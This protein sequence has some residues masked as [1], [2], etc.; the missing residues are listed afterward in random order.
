MTA[1]DIV[2]ELR[3]E[4]RNLVRCDLVTW[5]AG[6]VSARVPGWDRFLTTASEVSYDGRIPGSMVLCTLDGERLETDLVGRWTVS[7]LGAHR[8]PAVLMHGHGVYGQP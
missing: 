1:L 2:R 6:N 4:L 7:T 8:S 3:Q 5:T